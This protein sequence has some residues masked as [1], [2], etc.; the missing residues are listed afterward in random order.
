MHPFSKNEYLR[1]GF[2]LVV[3]NTYFLTETQC[4]Y[5]IR[6]IGVLAVSTRGLFD[7][8]VLVEKQR[9]VA[10]YTLDYAAQETTK[11]V[12]QYLKEIGM[13]DRITVELQ[14]AQWQRQEEITDNPAPS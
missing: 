8:P 14:P 11:H 9:I 2:R 12:Q 6:K 4:T 5:L 3:E 13:E 7:N 1:T 10:Y